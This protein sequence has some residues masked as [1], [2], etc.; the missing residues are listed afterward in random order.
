MN[1][2]T[3]EPAQGKQLIALIIKC[4]DETATSE[5]IEQLN[6]LLFG[7]PHACEIYLQQL[8]L[9]AQ[10]DRE[11]VGTKRVDPETMNPVFAQ[12]LMAHPAMAPPTL[13]QHPIRVW[14]EMDRAEVQPTPG[15]R[16]FDM[17]GNQRFWLCIVAAGL[18]AAVLVMPAFQR[19]QT[20]L[21]A[22]AAQ[23]TP[24]SVQAL[25]TSPQPMVQIGTLLLLDHCR[26]NQ[27]GST[28]AEAADTTGLLEGA[29]LSAGTLSLLEGVA[30]LRLNG[31][32]ELVLRGPTEVELIDAGSA[33]L[34]S[35]KVRVRAE[36][37][38][39]GFKLMTTAAE[40][41]DLGTEF[42]V[43][44]DSNGLTELH[45]IDGEVSYR[46]QNQPFE[47]TTVVTAG[48]AVRLSQQ[49]DAAEA[50]DAKSERFDHYI[51]A[52]FSPRTPI[53]WVAEDFASLPVA[54]DTE[55]DTMNR[56]GLIA[57]ESFD[58]PA[59]SHRPQELNGGL[60]WRG[61]WRLR[62][63]IEHRHPG[64]LNSLVD[65]LHIVE[66]EPRVWPSVND[67]ER[68]WLVPPGSIVRLRPL[69]VPLET[70]VAAVTYVALRIH[71]PKSQQ[72]PLDA[73]SVTAVEDV[74]LSFRSSERYFDECISFGFHADWTPRVQM[75]HGQ[76][77]GCLSK[78]GNDQDLLLVGKIMSNADGV[79]DL[80]FRVFGETEPIGLYE[81]TIWHVSGHNLKYRAKLDL[82]LLTATG[83]GQRLIH[84]LKIGRTWRSVV[85][86]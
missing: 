27:V 40:L 14:A 49:G 41:I 10:L 69:A 54:A 29:G 50:I 4:C 59:G 71:E 46:P 8:T 78:V 17:S 43:K 63:A 51:H 86:P 1:H 45:V 75:A 66:R 38:A 53:D 35:G 16:F 67:F 77:L 42:V 18:I 56:D 26:W 25:V 28:A 47:A 48:N 24:V 23:S 57:E 74:R 62:A 83:R 36:G 15:H 21:V 12:P 33:Y 39:A 22:K 13:N 70:N 58:Y 19:R 20:P 31:G 65:D 68:S 3:E 84:D 79:S 37:E 2:P 85:A 76:V 81:P 9:H 52:R 5:D 30:V 64:E 6:E 55:H 7:N 44:V 60:G 80:Y 73:G 61:P 34:R 82:V 11:F 72:Q 32:A